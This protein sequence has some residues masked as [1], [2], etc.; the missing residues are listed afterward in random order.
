MFGPLANRGR[1]RFYGLDVLVLTIAALAQA[2]VQNI[3]QLI[4][5]R[6]LL[7]FGVGA[8]YVLSP[9]IM[10]ENANARDRGK[11]LALGFGLTWGIGAAVACLVTMLLNACGVPSDWVWRIVLGLGAV[12]SASVIYLRRRLPETPRY[13]ARMEGSAAEYERVVEFVVGQPASIAPVKRDDTSAVFYF[14]THAKRIV[15]ACL[16]WFLFDLVAYSS[17]LFGPNLIAKSLGVSSGL[18]QVVMEL[19]FTVPGAL[20]GLALIDRV[21]RK[22]MQ[23]VGFMGMGVSLVLSVCCECISLARGLAFCFMAHRTSCRRW[24]PAPCPPLAC[25]AW[26]WCRPKFEEPSKAGLSR[27]GGWARP[28]RPS[29]FPRYLPRWVKERP[30]SCWVPC[31]PLRRSAHGSCFLK[32]E[33]FPWKKPRKNPLRDK[34]CPNTMKMARA[35]SCP[36]H[37]R[38]Q[39]PFTL[40]RFGLTSRRLVPVPER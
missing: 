35:N 36:C 12:P 25:S 19:A 37:L 28:S 11:S 14:R 26:N 6:F 22:P 7:G 27:P 32:P 39:S 21:G 1:K 38:F 2:F 10:G 8:D 13:V 23:I 5:I 20:V 4:A 18:F 40:S 31:V 34:K 16:L 29:S 33:P 3:D 24:G 15:T 9:V 30:F 17:I